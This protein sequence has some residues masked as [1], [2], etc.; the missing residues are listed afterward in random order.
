VLTTERLDA[1]LYPGWSSNW[2]DQRLRTA[3]VRMA[4][5]VSASRVLDLGA[6]AGIVR[7]MDVRDT[8]A[9]VCG[10]DLDRRVGANPFLHAAC[11]G[12]AARLPYRD[13]SFDVVFA[14]NVLEHLPAPLAVFREVRRVLTPGGCFL[15]KTPNRYHYVPAI[16]ALTPH[17]FH[18]RIAARRG[19]RH[20]DTFETAYRANTPAAINALASAAGL[21]VVS[22]EL[23]EGRPEYCRMHPALYLAGCMYERMVNATEA[24]R[25]FRVVMIGTLRK[26]SA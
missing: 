25:R 18:Q 15:F 1:R 21:D 14:N 26:P 17:R 10:V 6:G 7:Q 13:G 5:A 12:D 2:D 19:R 3:I 24:L 4:R 16:A 20:E 22:L 11:V 23:V 9:T 8:T